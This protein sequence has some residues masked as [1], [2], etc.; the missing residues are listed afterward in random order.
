MTSSLKRVIGYVKNT[1]RCLRCQQKG[2]GDYDGDVNSIFYEHRRHCDVNNINSTMGI[3][4]AWKSEQFRFA[5]YN[6]AEIRKF[7]T[8]ATC[9]RKFVRFNA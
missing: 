8:E 4:H 6:N 2:S 1:M 5:H 3:Q 9:K 7:R